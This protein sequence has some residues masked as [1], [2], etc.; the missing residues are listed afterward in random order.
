MDVAERMRTSIFDERKRHIE[1]GFGS[2]KRDIRSLEEHHGSR[3][4]AQYLIP[5]RNERLLEVFGMYFWHCNSGGW[6]RIRVGDTLKL[7]LANGIVAPR[8]KA[9]LQLLVELLQGW[10]CP[11]TASRFFFGQSCSPRCYR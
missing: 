7:E 10:H 8:W 11:V 1:D 4:I 3:Q 6:A 2:K 9:A 5:V